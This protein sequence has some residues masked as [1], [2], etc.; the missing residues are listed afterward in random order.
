MRVVLADLPAPVPLSRTLARQGQRARVEALGLLVASL[1]VALGLWLAYARQVQEIPVHPGVLVQEGQPFADA[2]GVF[3]GADERASAARLIAQWMA[4]QGPLTHVGALSRVQDPATGKALFTPA[5]IAA[6]KPGLAVRTAETY[7]IRTARAAGIFFLSFWLLH[8]VRR[9]R[10]TTGDPVLVPIA[11][12]L[13][14]LGF[15]AM[16][17][18]RDPLRDTD[19]ATGFVVGVAL[20]CLVFAVLSFVDFENPRF[21]RSTLLPFGAAVLLAAA[22][23][24]FGAGPGESGVKVNL[25]GGQ[26]IE[27]IRILAV[28]ALAS[29]FSRRWEP[30]REISA[31]IGRTP[32]VRRHLLLP[33]AA[34][35]KPLAVIV[36]T[37]L[38][39]FFLQR[40]LGPA[41]VLGCMALAMYGVAR[42]R[43]PLVAAGFLILI[44]AFALGYWLGF[45]ATLARRVS[46]WLDPWNN[47]RAG[48]DQIAHALW[49]LSSGGPLGSG[50]GVGD[51]H[52]VPAGQTDLIVSVIGE[53]LGFVG[54]VVIA[55]AYALMV[56]RI[57]RIS[58]R[59]PGDYAA[60]LALGCALSLAIPAIIIIGGQLGAV[61]L[62]GVAT[63]F[64]SFGKS[65]MVASFTAL[66]IA[67]AIATRTGP[68]RP[69][70]TRQLR[71][72]GW[73]LAALA[74]LLVGRAAWVQV[75][76]ADDVT[77]RPALVRQADGDVRYRYNP[78]LLLASRV[79]PRGSVL[80]RHGFVLATNEPARAEAF[81]D[82]LHTLG[83]G[84]SGECPTNEGAF[85]SAS[86]SVAAQA[87][88]CYPLGGRAF[89][90]IGESSR[91][92]N[93]AARN[94]SFVERDSNG[95]LQGFE[96]RARMVN[97][98]PRGGESETVVARDYRDLL[99]LLRNKGNPDH[100][101]VRRLVER[102]RDVQVTVDGPFQA[103]VAEALEARARAAGAGRGAAVVLDPSTGELLAIASYPWPDM[104]PS[105][106]TLA[107]VEPAALLDRARYGLY[108]P[109]STFKL[110]TAAAAL[111]RASPSA[112]PP[113][114]CEPLAGGR[115]GARLPGV[116]R[117]VRDDVLDHSAHGRVDLRKGL[118]VSCNAYFAQLA[119]YL[120]ADALA[121]A[122]APAQ[123]QVSS[124]RARLGPTLPHAGYGQGETVASPLRMA[125]AVAAI[126]TDGTIRE[127]SLVR[128]EGQGG[129]TEIRWLRPQDA[130]FLRGAMREVVTAGT[131]RSLAR[132]AVPIAGKTGTAE[133]SGAP[134]HS[135]FVGFA[136]YDSPRIAFAVIVEHA[137]YGGR[138]AAP[139]AG[140]IV[141]AARAAGILK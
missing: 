25:L 29:Y 37:L 22:L 103:L 53:E 116:S 20:G 7:R 3:P 113:F 128:T 106:R 31:P 121:G 79:L 73:T 66:A 101:D 4:A 97:V 43:V 134:S 68:V 110:V 114:M 67:S 64:L 132:H 130:A 61:P 85:S 16:L 78:R 74:S 62:S 115:V 50:A 127:A 19:A 1:A 5:D 45:P 55:L 137:G 12:L 86:L 118:I 117:P 126:A 23:V 96:D 24:M 57:L 8:L 9:L 87:P 35:V 28:L 104:D 47:A 49:A 6:V 129:T 94:T 93:W 10:R 98:H 26:P 33:R 136:P 59:A 138:I 100:P 139:L 38:V 77:L 108:P 88:R 30:L 13:S 111:N 63:P 107:P 11:G 14:G 2:L 119:V 83:A 135:W 125:R 112:L 21:R 39:F 133:V 15:M 80:D 92:V 89:H 72:A 44:G 51:G 17:A 91:Q 71:T 81:E 58:A 75:P 34:D 122:A 76:D 82:R 56:W 131:G 46:I 40:D 109:G 120:G 124:S 102:P 18:L 99:P 90:V 36:G 52:L 41:L 95:V 69:A 123:I 54:I 70:F 60:F 84:T 65:S 32:V 48:G 141:T 140:D 42:A 105:G 27:A